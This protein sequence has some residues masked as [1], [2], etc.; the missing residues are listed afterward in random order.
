MQPDLAEKAEAID[1]T[2]TS[3]A[4]LI[5]ELVDRL[6]V[7]LVHD[8][9][10][11]TY[12]I[13][14]RA[15]VRGVYA[16]RS[17]QFRSLLAQAFF[18]QHGRT[19][20]VASLADARLVLEGRAQHVGRLVDVALRVAGDDDSID[21]DLGDVRWRMVHITRDGWS[22]KPHGE[23][24]FR[25]AP[26]MLAL[27]DPISGGSLD[28]LRQFVS[29]DD[30][31]FT[32]IAAFLVNAI[33][34][35]GPYPILPLTGEQG[36]AKTTTARILRRLVDPNKADVRAEPRDNRDLIIAAN[37]GHIIALDNV[38]HLTG[39]FSDALCRLSTGGGFA[40]RTLYSDDEETIFSVMR[41]QILTSIGDVA[42]RPD[43][44]D[45]SLA[46]RLQP[47]PESERRTEEELRQGF[48]AAHPRLFGAL[49]DA[50][51]VALR[52]VREVERKTKSKP[53]MAD[54]YCWTLA[55]AAALGIDADA[56]ASVWSRTVDEAH[57]SILESS[58]IFAPLRILVERTG[59]WS[60]TATD[61]FAAFAPLV[62]ESIAKRRD[63]PKSAKALA[64]QVRSIAPALRRAGVDHS[65]PPRTS[66]ARL[67]VFTLRLTE[68]RQNAS[69]ASPASR[70][71]LDQRKTDDG[72]ASSGRHL[73]Q[74]AGASVIP[75]GRNND[76][77]DADDANDNGLRP[78]SASDD[79]EFIR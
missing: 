11:V 8:S 32:L 1:H 18:E 61:L 66:G 16:T 78:M 4:D 76:V 70:S 28:E 75:R 2:R 74:P 60:G 25:R 56:I 35:R 31:N 9:A 69:P 33:R 55:A 20:R 24:L 57:A 30:A 46:V 40:T 77:R 62:D 58:R 7:E 64:N 36:S 53:R 37:N 72:L 71:L 13:I 38:S 15:G 65:E 34:P 51:S 23:R 68:L 42:N 21:V 79:V 10:M 41:P 19:P 59:S 43:L 5:V 49:L 54:A 17:S 48:D 44:L 50:A 6:G 22:I 47:I 12:A 39:Q 14:E 67:H 27:P 63:W 52:N 73:R 26:G 29:V 45:R 3:Q